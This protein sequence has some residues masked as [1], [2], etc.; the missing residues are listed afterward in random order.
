MHINTTWSI[1]IH[2]VVCEG[3]SMEYNDNVMAE[4]SKCEAMNRAYLTAEPETRADT[5][6]G[7][8][9]A[10]RE[11]LTSLDPQKYAQWIG[12]YDDMIGR[13]HGM[14]GN[15]DRVVGRPSV[16]P[17]EDAPAPMRG[18]EEM[19]VRSSHTRGR[20]YPLMPFFPIFRRKR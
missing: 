8:M 4:N 3:E 18:E 19:R 10:E 16:V 12:A 1:Y 11:R 13:L 20:R 17:G 6:L 2:K 14:L 9:I 7:E 15:R 5:L